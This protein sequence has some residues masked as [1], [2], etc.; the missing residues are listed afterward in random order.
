MDSSNNDLAKI[1]ETEFRD[2]EITPEG[3]RNDEGELLPRAKNEPRMGMTAED[4]YV[5]DQWNKQMQRD[6]PNVDITWIDMISTYCYLHPEESKA[7]ALSRMNE[8]APVVK[9]ESPFKGM[10]Q[11][12]R[13]YT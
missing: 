5:I 4:E 3:W 13:V 10:A 12:E 1:I 7:Y 11:Y 9:S 2:G 8:T 6:F